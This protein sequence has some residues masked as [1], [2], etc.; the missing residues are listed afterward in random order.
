[1]ISRHFRPWSNLHLPHLKC[2]QLG[3]FCPC[4]YLLTHLE[5]TRLAFE[6]LKHPIVACS[7]M[8]H[9]I[10]CQNNGHWLLNYLRPPAFLLNAGIMYLKLEWCMMYEVLGGVKTRGDDGFERNITFSPVVC[11]LTRKLYRYKVNACFILFWHE[12]VTWLL[13]I[14]WI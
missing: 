11:F 13:T 9:S 12:K 6:I 2:L 7:R 1:M 4:L 8:L 5:Y 10:Y 3:R 14:H